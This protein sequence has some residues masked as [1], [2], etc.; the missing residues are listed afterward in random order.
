MKLEAAAA[1]RLLRITTTLVKDWLRAGQRT[2]RSRSRACAERHRRF[3]VAGRLPGIHRTSLLKEIFDAFPGMVKMF[4]ATTPTIRPA[5]GSSPT[6]AFTSSTSRTCT[7]WPKCGRWWGRTSASWATSPRGKRAG[8]G[9]VRPGAAGTRARVLARTISPQGLILSAGGGVSGTP[10]ANI[11]R[12]ERSGQFG[13]KENG[14]KGK[15]LMASRERRGWGPGKMRH[16]VRIDLKCPQM[17]YFL[18]S[19]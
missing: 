18:N 19:D 11:A 17:P 14:G 1:H 9:H 12:P 6:S 15:L 13:R 4:A 2:A 7:R 10:A 5:A 8:P 16:A 3:H